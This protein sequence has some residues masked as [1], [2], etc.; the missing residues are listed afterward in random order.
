MGEAKVGVGLFLLLGVRREGV[1]PRL[2]LE[3]TSVGDTA[4]QAVLTVQSLCSHILHLQQRRQIL[5]GENFCFLTL[6]N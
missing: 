2:G 6:K 1:R 4:T 5:P 3:E